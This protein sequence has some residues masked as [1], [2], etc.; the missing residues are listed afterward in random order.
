MIRKTKN[1]E[2]ADGMFVEYLLNNCE[3]QEHYV[4]KTVEIT[5]YLYYS[6]HL[7]EAS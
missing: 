7:Y 6:G 4:E 5:R 3:E 1:P 2:I